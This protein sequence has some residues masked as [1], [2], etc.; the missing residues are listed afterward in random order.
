MFDCEVED[1]TKKIETITKIF[2]V[3]RTYEQSV[4]TNEYIIKLLDYIAHAIATDKTKVSVV[5]P[6]NV[7]KLPVFAA[8]MK[9]G[10]E[11]N[12][13]SRDCKEFSIDLTD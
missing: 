12:F 5:L 7:D 11:I 1:T 6:S 8:V 10:F 3:K 13:D 4:N 9:A 2:T